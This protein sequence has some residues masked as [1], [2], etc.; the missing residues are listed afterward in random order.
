MRVLLLLLLLPASGFAETL[1]ARM[2]IGVI[3]PNGPLHQ[4]DAI[5]T[6]QSD[7][8]PFYISWEPNLN[9]TG[10][11]LVTSLDGTFDGKP[12][13]QIRARS[14]KPKLLPRRPF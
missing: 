3:G 5:V 6:L 14:P 2:V 8:G 12:A 11:Y 9:I 1:T 13:T 10:G 7:P 4:L